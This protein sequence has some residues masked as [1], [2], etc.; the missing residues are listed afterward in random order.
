M[1]EAQRWARAP[2]LTARCTEARLARTRP[3]VAATASHTSLRHFAFAP[4]A[5][6][7]GLP[8]FLAAARRGVVVGFGG[9]RAGAA[10]DGRGAFD[11][12]DLVAQLRGALELQVLGGLEHLFFEQLH[13]L[14]LV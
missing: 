8:D 12:V 14:G 7:F 3:S 13:Q 10:P 6:G 9:E 4:A 2:R 5:G 1:A 11:L